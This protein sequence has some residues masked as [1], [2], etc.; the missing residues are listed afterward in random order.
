MRTEAGNQFVYRDAQLALRGA[1]LERRLGMFRRL[2]LAVKERRPVG[3]NKG[4]CAFKAPIEVNRA[5]DRLDNVADDIV[6]Q[7]CIVLA[8]LLAE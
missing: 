2:A 8:R 4:F 5:D 6:A 7:I 3:P 1:F